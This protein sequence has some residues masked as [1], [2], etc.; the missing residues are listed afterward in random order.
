MVLSWVLKVFWSHISFQKPPR[1]KLSLF[2]FEITSSVSCHICLL[3]VFH[4]FHFS[5]S[6]YLSPCY[7]F[8]LNVLHLAAFL[9]F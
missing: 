4:T 8:G 2:V 6:H 5:E 3:R 9:S 1:F 7:H